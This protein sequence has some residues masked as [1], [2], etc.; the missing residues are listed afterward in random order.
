LDRLNNI[1]KQRL[2]AGQVMQSEHP[3]SDTLAAFVEQNLKAPQRET[4]LEHLAACPACREAVTL[5]IS[6]V[7]AQE[8]AGLS[9]KPIFQFPP[10]IRWASLVAALAVAVGVG[11]LLNEHESAPKQA[12]VSEAARSAVSTQQAPE[13]A[14]KAEPE[15]KNS[16]ASSQANKGVVN[17]SAD[18]PVP[19]SEKKKPN[20]A[21]GRNNTNPSAEAS[22]APALSVVSGGIAGRPSEYAKLNQG[23]TNAPLANQETKQKLVTTDAAQPAQSAPAVP[24]PPPAASAFS[25][26]QDVTLRGSAAHMQSAPTAATQTVEVVGETRA[27]ATDQAEAVQIPTKIT[28]AATVG[29]PVRRAPS[30]A[31]HGI[32][33]WAISDT[34][35]LQRSLQNGATTNVEPA[36]GMTV[37]AVAAEGIEVWAAGTQSDLSAKEWT[38]RPVLFHSSDAGKTWSRVEGPWQGPITEL[39][40][41]GKGNLG[42]STQKGIWVTSDGGK[43]WVPV[44]AKTKG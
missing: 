33:S 19:L 18:K 16:E 32:I 17:G 10:A 2:A 13:A 34:G 35:Q 12:F 29:G 7:P 28:P 22:V 42:V 41:S 26:Q 43:T 39:T 27:E 3:S 1:L 38:Q 23:T 31:F 15:A 5:A 11:I 40:L 36:P 9:R 24:S 37:R 6:E 8:V 44:N 25:N 30:N 21:T 20:L 4:L 14:A